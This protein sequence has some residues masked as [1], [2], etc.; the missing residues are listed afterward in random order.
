MRGEGWLERAATLEEHF[1]LVI[2]GI[3]GEILA[4]GIRGS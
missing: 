1:F 4:N 2:R 3:Y